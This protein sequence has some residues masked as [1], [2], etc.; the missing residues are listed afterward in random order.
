MLNITSVNSLES[1]T[2][3]KR[4][5]LFIGKWFYVGVYNAV[6]H[7]EALLYSIDLYGW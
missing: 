6:W 3:K 7:G 4:D 5:S 1:L 2:N